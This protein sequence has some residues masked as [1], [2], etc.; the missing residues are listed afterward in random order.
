[1]RQRPVKISPSILTADFGHLADEVRALEA[2]GADAIHLD[3]MDGVFVPNITVGLPIVRA[4]RAATQLPLDVHLMV[5]DADPFLKEFVDAGATN[6]TVHAEACRHLHSTVQRIAA[7]GCG[8]GVAI[9]PGTSIEQVRE[10][11]PFVDLVL[12]MTVNPGFGGQQFIETMTSKIRRMRRLQE[13]LNPTCDLQVDGG[14]YPFNID[15]VVRAGANNIVVGSAVFNAKA[16]PAENIHVL[17]EA[18]RN[19]TLQHA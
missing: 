7:L 15:D 19:H 13:D 10:V 1:M 17:R 12:V 4:V 14:I 2:G 5:H 6:L 8:V 18:V 16:S 11:L 3:V 9:N